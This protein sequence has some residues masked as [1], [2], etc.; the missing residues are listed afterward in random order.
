MRNPAASPGRRG[1]A[2]G[3]IVRSRGGRRRNRLARRRRSREPRPAVAVSVRRFPCRERVRRGRGAVWP[4]A[5]SRRGSCCSR[6]FRASG[7]V[8]KA[9][10]RRPR[11]RRTSLGRARRPL[12]IARPRAMESK[13][14][15]GCA[16][17]SWRPAVAAPVRRVPG[18]GAHRRRERVGRRR[19]AAGR[20]HR[21][22]VRGVRRRER[23]GRRRG[24]EGPSRERAEADAGVEIP[25]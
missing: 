9:R 6:N 10:P 4:I 15:A 12:A 8:C 13:C 7:L 24:A 25:R 19:G 14:R 22:I 1:S 16:G 11:L 5:R 2:R 17:E 20:D 3:P 23:V 21:P 18:A